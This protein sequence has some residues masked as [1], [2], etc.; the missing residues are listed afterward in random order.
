MRSAPGVLAL[1]L[2]ACLSAPPA[3]A[4]AIEGE[5]IG[6]LVGSAGSLFLR[7]SIGG[8]GGNVAGRA[9]IPARGEFG[10]LLHDVE[11]S[12]RRLTFEIPGN[13]GNLRVEGEFRGDG[14]ITGTVTQRGVR[15]GVELVRLHSGWRDALR[16]FL[17]TYRGA[18][19]EDVLL[20][21]EGAGGP[22]YVDYLT[23]RTGLL[24]ATSADT[25]VAGPSVLAGYPVE[26]TARFARDPATH[27]MTVTWTRRDGTARTARRAAFYR[28]EP[29]V[30]A[31]ADGTSL[32]GTLLVP[33]G[34]GP[35]PAVV[36]I[37]GSGRL[38]HTALLPLADPL[39]RSGIAVLLHDRRGVGA[40]GG[41]FARATF[42]DL[43]EDALAGVR[44]L[45]GRREINAR[46]IGLV[47]SSLGGWVA[48]LAA[49]RSPAVS[50]VILEAAPV[51]TPAE[52]ERLRVESQMRADGRPEADIEQALAF[53]DRK[54]EVARTGDG[55]PDLERLMAR[56]AR[57]G[58]LP[59][60]NPP[61]SLD[62]LRWNGT[63]VF[64]YD[65]R[66]ALAALRVSVLV[67]YGALDRIVPPAASRA[68][69]EAALRGAGNRDVTVRVL[70]AANHN[71]FRAVTGAP[72]EAPGLT[73]FAPGYF[74]AR[75][76][77][78]RERVDEGRPVAAV[79]PEDA[80]TAAGAEPAPPAGSGVHQA[81]RE[82]VRA[83]IPPGSES[84]PV[85]DPAL[86]R[87]QA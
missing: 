41:S 14:R 50:F 22:A 20:F 54:F 15:A 27:V 68:R 45:A 62:N 51:V 74:E 8:D 7:V 10:V 38:A 48:P 5:W 4:G 69:I 49:S 3:A 6:A 44:L 71:F 84:E 61:A 29:V 59:Y 2:A 21:Y 35:H 18:A 11:A 24:F 63:H 55:W 12:D 79:A 37:Q 85:R 19:D 25:F 67:L 83:P 30:Y 80:P 47:G 78:L 86:R 87:H 52:H 39:A 57:E 66:P 28:T 40:S 73:G 76:A 46:Q 81:E 64:P 26:T 33:N 23:G 16:P 32:S 36:M 9:D 13:M 70:D 60:T 31:S 58:W 43:A 42:D 34:A 17:G 53:M 77:W 1:A 75:T 56:G 65:P 82:G 72:G